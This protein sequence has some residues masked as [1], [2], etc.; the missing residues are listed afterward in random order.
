M[1]PAY[2]A[3]PAVVLAV[4]AG[5][6]WYWRATE[7]DRSIQRAFEKDAE[8]FH[9][10]QYKM[11]DGAKEATADIQKGELRLKS[12]GCIRAPWMIEEMEELYGVKHDWLGGP[13]VTDDVSNYE[14]SYNRVVWGHLIRTYHLTREQME[15]G[16]YNRFRKKH[17]NSAN[18]SPEATTSARTPAADAPVAPAGGRASS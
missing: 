18:K 13:F 5:Y 2:L 3:F 10:A 6:Y 17:E 16:A 15:T 14:D 1:K 8:F 9:Y 12:T 7:T 4:F 11:R